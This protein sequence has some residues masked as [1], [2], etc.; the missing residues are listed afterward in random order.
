[1][2]KAKSTKTSIKA[3]LGLKDVADGNVVTALT[4]SYNGVL[5]NSAYPNSPI[6][7]VSYKANI[8]KLVRW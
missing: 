7:L 8:D 6:D 2:A 3:K 5:N 1:M 4:A